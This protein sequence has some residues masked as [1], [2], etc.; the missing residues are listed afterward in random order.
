MFFFDLLV[1]HIFIFYLEL[2]ITHETI[3]PYFILFI[4]LA[5]ALVLLISI[6]LLLFMG[7]YMKSIWKKNELVDEFQA[8]DS[9]FGHPYLIS[10]LYLL[11]I[12]YYVAK[13]LM[14]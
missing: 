10:L 8:V 6:I 5:L 3:F 1:S 9:Y 13:I 7:D 12:V 2:R 14:V 4:H 11:L